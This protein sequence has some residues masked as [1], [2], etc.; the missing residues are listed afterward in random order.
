MDRATQIKNA[1][2]TLDRILKSSERRERQATVDEQRRRPEGHFH[3]AETYFVSAR[4]LREFKHA[5]HSDHPVRLLYYTAQEV[6]LKAFLRLHGLSTL[7]LASRKFGHRYCCLVE[8]T[9][10]LGRSLND[11]DYAVLYFLSYSDER[12]RVRY[13]ETGF[14]QW[15]DVDDL[16]RTCANIRQLVCER[17]QGA[18][19]PVRLQAADFGPRHKRDT[20]QN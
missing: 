4:K 14:A 7:E 20:E 9:T 11:E 2:A 12:E 6:Y 18:G 10:T 3:I 5:G 19:L 1:K 16:D 15:V 17:L 13:I 8:R